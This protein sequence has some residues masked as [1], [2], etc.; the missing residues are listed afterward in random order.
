[1][2]SFETGNYNSILENVIITI[3]D[4][5]NVTTQ[6][7]K[8]SSSNHDLLQLSSLVTGWICWKFYGIGG[9][10]VLNKGVCKQKLWSK[11]IYIEG[12]FLLIDILSS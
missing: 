11:R 1:M 2:P 4:V 8:F 5:S 6:V 7:F 10:S 12:V 3:F 9:P